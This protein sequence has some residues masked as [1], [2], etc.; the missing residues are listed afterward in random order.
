METEVHI[1]GTLPVIGIIVGMLLFWIAS[2][3]RNDRL[4]RMPWHRALLR[5]LGVAAMVLGSF[6]LIGLATHVFF[7]VAWTVAAVV[8]LASIFRYYNSERHSLIWMLTVAAERGIPLNSAV[9]A[10]AEERNDRIG[11]QAAKL[12]D[13]LEAGVP[14]GTGSEEIRDP[15]I[16]RHVAGR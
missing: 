11:L 15:C 10:F 5:A 6:A 8:L 14:P 16:V 12:A 4:G 2:R 3:G 1:A 13:Y 7:I 9:M